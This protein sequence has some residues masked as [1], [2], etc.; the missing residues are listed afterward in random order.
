MQKETNTENTYRLLGF[1]ISVKWLTLF[2]FYQATILKALDFMSTYS[3]QET[4]VKLLLIDTSFFQKKNSCKPECT[5]NKCNPVLGKM[6]VMNEIFQNLFITCIYISSRL[7]FQIQLIVL[8]SMFLCKPKCKQTT[9]DVTSVLWYHWLG[10]YWVKSSSR[11]CWHNIV[12]ESVAIQRL[13]EIWDYNSSSK[14]CI[15]HSAMSDF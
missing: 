1:V 8:Y 14:F 13:H 15:R 3:I 11:T 10:H 7:Q 2:R 6:N 12:K 5:K 9:D 4:N